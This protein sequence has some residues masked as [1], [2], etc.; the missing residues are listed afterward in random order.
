MDRNFQSRVNARGTQKQ[1]MT[2]E[3]LVYKLKKLPQQNVVMLGIG[4]S[5]TSEVT[6]VV[7]ESYILLADDYTSK[8]SVGYTKL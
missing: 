6:I 4:G 2:V 3:A 7:G 8:L 1:E 5:C